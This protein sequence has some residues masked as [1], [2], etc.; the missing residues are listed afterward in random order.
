MC[1]DRNVKENDVH[2][3]AATAAATTLR[4]VAP[5]VEPNSLEHLFREHYA[6]IFRTAYRITGS[7]TDAEDVLQ[8]IFLRL[9]SG[10]EQR[11]QTPNPAAYLR[12]ASVNAALDL[13]RGRQRA[14][15]ISL[16]SVEPTNEFL[17]SSGFNP[18]Q[19]CADRELCALVREAITKLG[20]RAATVF[21]LRYIEGYDN[22]EIAEA[23]GASQMVVAVT[24]HRARTRL[25]REIN[26]YLEKHHE[27]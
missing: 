12:R 25:R 8:T 10:K 23:V 6:Q 26:Q 2:T 19:E 9:A 7:V 15:L 21:V 11:D 24:L 22:R 18:E 13:M 4:A 20:E 27:A 14:R 3:I 17:N 1:D 5:V 16:E